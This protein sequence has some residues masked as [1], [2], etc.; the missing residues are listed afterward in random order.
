MQRTSSH[1][2]RRFGAK[3]SRE[4]L[5]CLGASCAATGE[6]NEALCHSRRYIWFTSYSFGRC[7]SFLVTDKQISN[8]LDAANNAIWAIG[9]LLVVFTAGKYQND[10][11]E[12]IQKHLEDILTFTF[13]ILDSED[14]PELL[15]TMKKLSLYSY[16]HLCIF[17]CNSQIPLQC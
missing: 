1:W 15:G 10:P 16:L 7:L 9:E 12:F 5:S 8:A 3:C 4:N 11:P 6:W 2:F 14:G 13:H 17:I